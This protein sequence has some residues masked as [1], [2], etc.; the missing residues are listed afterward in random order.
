[1][2]GWGKG[3]NAKVVDHHLAV[4]QEGKKS[5]KTAQ[6][7]SVKWHQHWTLEISTRPE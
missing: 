2:V 4:D 5:G 7:L 3:Y 1:M 6:K